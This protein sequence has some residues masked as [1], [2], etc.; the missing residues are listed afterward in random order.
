MQK[1]PGKFKNS[2]EALYRQFL[3]TPLHDSLQKIFAIP[4]EEKEISIIEIVKS[5]G[6][7][8]NTKNHHFSRNYQ[9]S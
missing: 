7:Q 1:P 9:L 3:K 2:S 8:V 4:Q 5:R 6:T